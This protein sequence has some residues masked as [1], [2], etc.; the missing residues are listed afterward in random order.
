LLLPLLLVS[1]AV[2][3]VVPVLAYVVVAY[4]QT[5]TAGL[6]PVGKEQ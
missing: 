5:G 6:R 2:V 4:L 1:N 3:L